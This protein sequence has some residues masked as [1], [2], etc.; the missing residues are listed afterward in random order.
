MSPKQLELDPRSLNLHIYYEDEF[1]IVLYKPRG[2]SMHPGAS[3]SNETT[4]AHALVSHAQSLSDKGGEFRPGIVH[5]LDK[6]TEGIVVIAKNNEVHEDLSLQFSSR[7]IE[8]A[9][10]ALCYGKFPRTGLKI[11]APIGRNPRDRKKMA[12]VS[13][14]K[15]AITDVKFIDTFEEGFSWVECK[16]QTGRTHQIRVHLSHKKFPI[17]NDPAYAKKRNLQLSEKKLAVLNDLKGQALIAYKLGFI[18]PVTSKKI[19]FEAEKPEWLKILTT[20]E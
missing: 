14:G 20:K 12:V 4:L 17:M 2:I 16:L 6:D 7:T 13:S 9:Y 18:H 10:W 5:R 8:R 1:L 19:Y 3:R 15:E 11:N